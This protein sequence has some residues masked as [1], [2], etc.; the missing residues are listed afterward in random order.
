MGSRLAVA[1]DAIAPSD[2]PRF[3]E[4]TQLNEE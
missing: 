3:A 2:L 1:I 4:G